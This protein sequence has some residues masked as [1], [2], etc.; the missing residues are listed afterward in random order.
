M[1]DHHLLEKQLAESPFS[2]EHFT[3]E[4]KLNVMRRAKNGKKKSSISRWAPVLLIPLAVG[5]LTVGLL[6]EQSTQSPRAA[7]WHEG[8]AF[9]E[10]GELLFTIYPDPNVTA[11][12]TFGYLFSFEASFHAFEGKRLE[13]QAEH[14]RT[15]V[16]EELSSELITTPSS[17][18]DSLQ[19]YTAQFAL[20]IG[21]EWII[22][23]LLDDVPYGNSLLTLEDPMPWSP[24]PVFSS[25]SSSMRGE[26]GKIGII[27]VDFRA[28]QAQKVMWHF[29]GGVDSLD[30]PFQVK[31]VKEHSE[32]MIE[33]F[34]SAPFSSANA[35]AGALNGADRHTVS[36][37]ELPEAGKWRL[38]PYVG[39][40]LLD[41]VV[42]EVQP[43][44][45]R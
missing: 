44:I 24:S 13:I 14:R 45:A 4:L 15:G 42:V 16:R 12:V 3:Q 33:V 35:L 32:A 21:G 30:G 41:P 25:D 29:W 20:P 38:L 11:G 8:T 18:Y 39:G 28:G 40:R 31:A 27:D 2:N 22:T 26:E 17:G 7:A 43:S 37:I 19:R 34:S 23:V 9:N 5:A 36:S 10:Q 1:S 6:T